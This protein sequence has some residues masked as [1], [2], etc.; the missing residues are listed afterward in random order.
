[1]NIFNDHE[2][3]LIPRHSNTVSSCEGPMRLMWLFGLVCKELNSYYQVQVLNSFVQDTQFIT[4][5]IV[6]VI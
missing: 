6:P 5:C 1:M 4:R 2:V 3:V